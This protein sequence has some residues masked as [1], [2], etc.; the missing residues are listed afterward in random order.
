VPTRFIIAALAVI[1][2]AFALDG[3]AYDHAVFAGVY[4]RDWGR[5]LRVLGFWPTWV[6][7]GLLVWLHER[8]STT[9]ATRRAALIIAAPALTGIVAEILKLVFR[10]LRPEVNAGEYVFRPFTERTFSTSGL[11]MPSSHTMVAF[12]A[13]VALGF[14]Y[15]RTRWVWYALAAGCGI[16]R[17]LDHRHYVSDVAVGAVAAVATT[18]LFLRRFGRVSASAAP[19]SP[20]A[21]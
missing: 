2:L 14:L 12:G 11:A 15:P 21:A 20:G 10:R 18:A 9:G 8:G 4:D 16:T 1:A 5:L 13:A 3:W 6:L 7:A 17:I 19:Q